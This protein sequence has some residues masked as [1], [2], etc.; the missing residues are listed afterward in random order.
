[1]LTAGDTAPDFTLPKAGGAAYND[2]EAFTLSDAFGDGPIVLAFY[3][4]AF[5]RGCTAEMC[6]FRDSMSLFNA[7][8]AQ[9]YGISVDLPFSQNIWMRQ[10]GFDFPMLSDWDHEVI[11]TYGVVREDMYGMLEVAERSVFVLDS[12]GTIRHTWVEGEGD[13]DFEAFVA[14]LGDV[15]ADLAEA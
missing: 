10:E 9:V 13:V 12:E 15:V 5:T 4:A 11:H 14:D 6:A 7:V 2:F 8:D 3:P 1:M